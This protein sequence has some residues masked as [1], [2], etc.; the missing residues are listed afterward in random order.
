M[1]QRESA[2]A[3]GEPM[4]MKLMKQNK[5]WRTLGRLFAS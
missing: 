3:T 1:K 4:S 5:G 2:P